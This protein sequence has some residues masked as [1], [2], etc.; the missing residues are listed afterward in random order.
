M[1]TATP[2]T[3]LITALLGVASGGVVFGVITNAR[4]PFVGSHRTAFYLLVVLGMTMCSL[5]MQTEKYGWLS[6]FTLSGIL[7]GTAALLLTVLMALGV[8]LPY[9]HN[10]RDAIIALAAIMVVKIVVARIRGFV[11]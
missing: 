4:I 2:L 3:N 10:Y 1:L 8:K 7:A 9:I 6:P 11:A 5:S